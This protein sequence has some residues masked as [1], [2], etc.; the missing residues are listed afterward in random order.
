MKYFVLVCFYFLLNT[1]SYSQLGNAL[2]GTNEIVRVKNSVEIEGSPYLFDTWYPGSIT[3]NLGKTY[4]NLLIKYDIYKERVEYTENGKVYEINTGIYKT[5]TIDALSTDATN[6]NRLIFKNNLAL[7]GFSKLVY[8]QVLAEG[9]YS[10][11]KKP[12]VLFVE[13]NVQ[14]YGTTTVRKRFQSK[15]YYYLKYE[16]EVKE[17]KLSKNS[18]I[19]AFPN[20]K[21]K[22]K[23]TRIKSEIDLQ[24]FLTL[25]N[26][27]L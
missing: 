27:E 23:S 5:F 20:L 26:N 14:S 12:R 8:A 6:I 9:T 11:Y 17:I 22:I 3:D 10:F 24:V 1:K 15:E 7:P 13:D 16:S 21:D 19:D 25:L 4:S 2:T 18:V